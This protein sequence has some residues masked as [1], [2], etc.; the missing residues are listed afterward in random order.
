MAVER[1]ASP[2]YRI[3][4]DVAVRLLE[5]DEHAVHAATST[6]ISV[7]AIQ[8]ACAPPLIEALVGQAEFPHFCELKF[9]LPGH[10]HEFIITG[11]VQTH[12]RVSHDRYLLVLLFI[13]MSQGEHEL[14]VSAL[15]G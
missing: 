11:R 9:I 3:S 15:S 13:Q 2:R 14:L 4:C 6:E 10:A 7:A 5:S 12:R 8:L 1:R